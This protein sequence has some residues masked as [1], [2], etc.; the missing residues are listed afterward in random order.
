[1]PLPMAGEDYD[2]TYTVSE[3]SNNLCK[4]CDA[5]WVRI[6]IL[7]HCLVIYLWKT[8]FVIAL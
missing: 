6:N 7:Q 4:S 1:M 8:P 5:D 3:D 2:V